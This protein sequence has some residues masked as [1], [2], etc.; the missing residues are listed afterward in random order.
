MVPERSMKRASKSKRP[1]YIVVA[2]ILI[3][4][5]TGIWF[6]IEYANSDGLAVRICPPGERQ[7]RILHVAFRERRGTHFVMVPGG[8]AV[9]LGLFSLFFKDKRPPERPSN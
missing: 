8:R 7:F 4:M 5:L 2:V 3:P 6:A 9:Y 1:V